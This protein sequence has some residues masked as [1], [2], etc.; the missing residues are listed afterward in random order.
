MNP[1]I[2]IGKNIAILRTIKG[3]KQSVF[4]K[5]IG[6]TQQAVSKMEN[7]TNISY[8]RL[9]HVSQ[10]LGVSIET[11]RSFDESVIK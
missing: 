10:I 7:S 8:S 2:N 3:I 9:V 11:I 1:S 6:I 5:S 4:A